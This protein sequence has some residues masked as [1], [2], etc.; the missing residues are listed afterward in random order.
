[1]N[2]ENIIFEKKKGIATI[3]LNRPEKLNAWSAQMSEEF[4]DALND[5]DNDHMVR[6][7]VITGAGRAFCAGADVGGFDKAIKAK[8]SPVQRVRYETKRVYALLWRNDNLS[9]KT[10]NCFSET[11]GS[12]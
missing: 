2:Y 6:V 1:V 7:V 3:T 9:S 8:L 4:R 10:V 12:S 5:I 11:I